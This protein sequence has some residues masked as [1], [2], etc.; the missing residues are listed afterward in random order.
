MSNQDYILLL[1]TRLGQL[2][3]LYH[4]AICDEERYELLMDIRLTEHAITE[5]ENE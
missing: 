3:E 5:L 2:I 1:A 4:A